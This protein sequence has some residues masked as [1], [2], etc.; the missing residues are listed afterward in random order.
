MNIIQ[1]QDRL[2]G[3]TDDALIGYVENPTGQVPTYLALGEIGR[4]EN[5]RKEYQAQPQPNQTVAEE[6][7]AQLSM[8]TGI[9]ALTSN[10]GAQLPPEEVMSTSPTYTKHRPKL[11]SRRYCLQ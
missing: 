3:V 2:K 5:M 10:M 11:S 9:G 6:M 7:V 4:R 1:V 8:P